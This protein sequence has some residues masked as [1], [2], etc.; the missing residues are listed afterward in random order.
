MGVG[1]DGGHVR[2]RPGRAGD[3]PHAGGAGRCRARGRAEQ[4][5]YAVGAVRGR[6]LDAEGGGEAALVG[7]HGGTGGGVDLGTGQGLAAL[8]PAYAGSCAGTTRSRFS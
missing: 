8:A 7:H 1:V 2:G 4:L 5:P 3:L 6:E